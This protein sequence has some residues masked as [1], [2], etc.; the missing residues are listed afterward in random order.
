MAS[1]AI[2]SKKLEKRLDYIA[3]GFRRAKVSRAREH[4]LDQAAKQEGLL[5][6]LWQSWCGFV[7][8]VV[9]ESS[10]GAVTTGNAQ[11]TSPYAALTLD[12]LR[13][14]ASKAARGNPI[15]AAITPIA[16]FHA[17]PTWGDLNKATLIL[18]VLSPSNAL[19][20]QSGLGVLTLSKDVQIVRNAAAH[21]SSDR[22]SDVRSMQLRYL[23]TSFRH[24]SD[25][26]FWTESGTGNDAWE[27]WIDEFRASPAIAIS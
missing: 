21:L 2:S 8:S 16:G 20:I 22:I 11:T 15:P 1:L 12:Q 17:E 27:I 3:E 6:A 18:N 19:S 4:F 10:A 14:V 9:L 24:P 26:V 23:N 13:H 7:R 5:S 25:A